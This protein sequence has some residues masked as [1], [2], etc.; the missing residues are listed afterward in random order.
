MDEYG[1]GGEATF[2]EEWAYGLGGIFGSIFGVVKG[3]VKTGVG[4]VKGFVTG[5]PVGAVAG[6]V[7]T[8][9]GQ[10]FPGQDPYQPD[11]TQYASRPST[12]AITQY[13]PPQWP[14]APTQKLD[15]KS[16][17][18]QALAAARDSMFSAG[19]RFI[20][21]TPAG[22][23]AIRQ[24]VRGDVQKTVMKWGLPVG[25]GAVA[26]LAIMLMRR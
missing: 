4:A 22:E 24:Q 10:L 11:P 14:G 2:E 21:G 16:V 25:I 23:E 26:L 9:A 20:A 1:F 15:I 8:A 6:G 18:Q 12:T 7:S 19:G 5:G 13:Q 17:I 3:V